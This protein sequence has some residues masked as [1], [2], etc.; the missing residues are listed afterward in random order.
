MIHAISLP[1]VDLSAET[2]RQV[3]I[4]AGTPDTYQ[5]HPTTVLLPDGRTLLCVWTLDHGGACGPMA[6]SEDGGR[7]W[8][9]PL[10]VPANWQSVR[11]CPALYR[12]PDPQ[13][14]ARLFVFAGQGPDGAMHQAHS[15][16]EGRTWTPMHSNGLAG[17]MPFCAI[18]PVEGGRRLLGMANIRRPGERTEERSNVVAQ[19]LSE[20]GGIT[21]SPWRVVLDIPGC[22]PCEPCLVRSPDGRR[23]LCLMRENNRSLNSWRPLSE[24]AGRTGSPAEQPEAALTG[25]RH[26]ARQTPDGRLVVAFRDMAA[27]S[28]THGHFVAWV[29]TYADAAGGGE[30]QYRVKLLHNHA[31]TDCGY[32]GLELLP[33]GMLV[34]TTYLKYRPGPERHSVVAARFALAET[35][36]RLRQAGAPPGRHG[37]LRQNSPTRLTGRTAPMAALPA[38]AV[39]PPAGPGCGCFGAPRLL[40]P[41]PADE[42]CAHLSWPKVARASDGTLVLAYVAGRFHGVHGEGCPAVSLS[43]DGGCTFTPPHVLKHFDAGTR[44]TAAGNLALGVAEDGALVILSMAYRGDEANTV[45]GWRSADGGVTW[46]PADTSTLSDNQT[47]SAF[48]EVFP[49]PGRGLAVCGHYRAGSRPHAE[50][51]WIAYSRD[52]G[53]SWGPPRRILPGPLFEPSI[54]FAGGRFVGLIRARA[55]GSRCYKQV[56]SDDMGETWQARDADM[57]PRDAPVTLPSPCLVVDG[58]DPSRLYALR[59]ERAAPANLPGEISLWT[60]D[61]AALLWQRL[62]TVASF[63]VELGECNDFGYPW[64]AQVADDTWFLAFYCGRAHGA[65]ALYGMPIRPAASPAPVGPV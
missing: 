41:A 60:A 2:D 14:R 16:D 63:P 6:R 42:R 57:P 40:V 13:G 55:G 19:S 26:V 49:V 20:D 45:D 38:P 10:P 8:R 47:G 51:L 36:A 48:G 34:A 65:N 18:L 7:T 59:T 46:R 9:G 64:M 3:V 54:R 30:G 39:P 1:T 29:G 53:R 31:G 37:R 52:H 35:D 5:G 27:G 21:W 23:I 24:A 61:A 50:G 15:E 33:D 56:V 12:L 22:K 4:A 17:V 62:G 43:D 25:D 32:P 44:C 11:N 58:A 28:P